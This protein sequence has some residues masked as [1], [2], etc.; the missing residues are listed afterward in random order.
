MPIYQKW[1][2]VCPITGTEAIQDNPGLPDKWGEVNKDVYAPQGLYVIAQ[3]I[4]KH[5]DASY[6]EITGTQ[7]PSSTLDNWQ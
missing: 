2:F 6:T 5:P 7:F 4:I 1:H 3:R